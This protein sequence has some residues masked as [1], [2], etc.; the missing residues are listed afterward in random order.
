MRGGF[1]REQ[2]EITLSVA[3][4]CSTPSAPADTHWRAN[5]RERFC[6]WKDGESHQEVK[7][8][9]ERAAFFALAESKLTSGAI[10]ISI[11]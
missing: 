11:S 9:L 6:E 8:R 10:S 5:F 4:H 3:A 2:S 1:F 7:E